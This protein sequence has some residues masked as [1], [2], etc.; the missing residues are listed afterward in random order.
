M[1]EFGLASPRIANNFG[2]AALED[3]SSA[4][5]FLGTAIGDSG[6]QVSPSI[7]YVE[8]PGFDTSAATFSSSSVAAR[9]RFLWLFEE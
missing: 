7:Q 8:N 9:V 2:H 6:A 5:A 4:E 1:L 3:V